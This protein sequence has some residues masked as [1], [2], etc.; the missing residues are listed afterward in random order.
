[1]DPISTAGNAV[2]SAVTWLQ[3]LAPGG[4]GLLI[5][6]IAVLG[7]LSLLAARRR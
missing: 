1:M 6:P 7:I 5:L 2:H 3:G 4:F